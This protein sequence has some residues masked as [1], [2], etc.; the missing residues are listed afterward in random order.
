[1]INFKKIILEILSEE[2]DI[3]YSYTRKHADAYYRGMHDDN[4]NLPYS[5]STNGYLDSPHTH[6]SD[7]KPHLEALDNA[8]KTHHPNW[9][10][11]DAYNAG[12]S[13][14]KI[15]INKWKGTRTGLSTL[16]KMQDE[17]ASAAGHH[18]DVINHHNKLTRSV[19]IE[20]FEDGELEDL[21]KIAKPVL[22]RI[23]TVNKLNPNS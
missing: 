9:S 15:A 10:P 7:A 18:P 17:A 14:Q 22:N 1:M 23:K 8:I 16:Y 11:E 5:K 2:P 21:S 19:P 20:H 13:V 12:Q 6:L 4:H 3:P